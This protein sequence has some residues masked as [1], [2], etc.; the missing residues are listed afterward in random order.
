MAEINKVSSSIG[1][2]FAMSTRSG[3]AAIREVGSLAERQ[4]KRIV[5]ECLKPKSFQKKLGISGSQK[6]LDGIA[7]LAASLF[8]WETKSSLPGKGSAAL[9]RLRDQILAYQKSGS[10][11]KY[12]LV[13][14]DKFTKKEMQGLLKYFRSEGVDVSGVKIFNGLVHFA[15]WVGQTHATLCLEK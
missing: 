10:T 9:Y 3:W 12:H 13:I 14:A 1:S 15:A 4:V 7:E 6:K 11:E 2:K 8:K 5:E